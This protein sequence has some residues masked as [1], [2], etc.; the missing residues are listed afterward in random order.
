MG[1]E[2]LAP[3]GIQSP[4]LAA[5]SESLYRLSYIGPWFAGTEWFNC[6]SYHV[7]R[8]LRC[9]DGLLRSCSVFGQLLLLLRFENTCS[10]KRF[11][12]CFQHWECLVSKCLLSFLRFTLSLPNI[13][14]QRQFKSWGG[15]SSLL[16]PSFRTVA[17]LGSPTAVASNHNSR[18]WQKLGI[19]INRNLSIHFL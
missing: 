2:N 9:S 19:L 7:V 12:L 13:S 16:F 10:L 11:C 15:H 6:S 18:H 5:L 4:D 3:T 1:A 14:Q 17:Q 8:L